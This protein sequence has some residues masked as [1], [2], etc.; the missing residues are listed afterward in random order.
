MTIARDA[1]SAFSKSAA[2]VAIRK[3]SA[4][5]VRFAGLEVIFLTVAGPLASTREQMSNFHYP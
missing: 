2:N 5:G 1:I 4:V 3:A